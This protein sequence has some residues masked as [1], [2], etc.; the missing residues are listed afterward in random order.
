MESKE[1]KSSQDIFE[2]VCMS[3]INTLERFD[4]DTVY[5]P[6]N[7]ILL[8]GKKISGSAQMKKG[9]IVLIHGTLLL[10]TNLELMNTVLKKSK[11]AKVSTICKEIGYAP[12][13]RDTKEGLKKEFEMYFDA[14]IEKTMFSTYEN[15]VIE[16][17]LKERYLNNA[18]NFM[19]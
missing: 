2:N 14:I 16:K 10:D 5:K 8:N 1:L 12:S 4:L 19:R 18:W 15:N 7:D 11:N 6:P 13:M 3:I 17:L 9:N